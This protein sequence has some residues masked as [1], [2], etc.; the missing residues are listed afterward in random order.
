[1]L[2]VIFAP[3][4]RWLPSRLTVVWLIANHEGQ[5][6]I[7]TANYRECS[8]I[9]AATRLALADVHVAAKLWKMMEPPRAVDADW[10]ERE[11]EFY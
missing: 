8:F 3:N 9:R 5:A 7:D 2:K 11:A 4:F 6:A 10:Q 1:M